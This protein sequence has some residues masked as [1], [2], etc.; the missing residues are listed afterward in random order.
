M[1]EDRISKLFLIFAELAKIGGQSETTKIFPNAEVIDAAP[2]D[3]TSD[4][5]IVKDEQGYYIPAVVVPGLNA[6]VGDLVNLLYIKGTEPIAF[7]QG[8]GS[9]S[10]E[11][12]PTQI[13]Q[14]LY[15]IDGTSFTVQLPL[16][17]PGGWL[18][19]DD[20]ILLVV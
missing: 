4:Y 12:I 8:S 19:N 10:P 9:T 18:I 13:G 2:A 16:T 3:L 20:G 17:G 1:S 11:N 14:I 6:S 5:I 7:Q 15:S